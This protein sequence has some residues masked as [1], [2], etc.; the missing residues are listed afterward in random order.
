MARPEMGNSNNSKE[1]HDEQQGDHVGQ[2][3][4]ILCLAGEDLDDSVGDH[5]NADAVADGAGDGHGK[6][7]QEDRNDLIEIVE[8]HVLQTL[9]V[10][11]V[12]LMT[13]TDAG[14]G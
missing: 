10:E 7:H 5:G 9:H 4:N 14:K 1:L 13:R 11:T 12:V 6:E 2:D 8:V 3:G